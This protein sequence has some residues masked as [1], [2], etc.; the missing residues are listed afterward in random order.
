MIWFLVLFEG[1]LQVCDAVLDTL[2]DSQVFEVG[3][4]LQ[5]LCEENKLQ[6]LA[7]KASLAP[8]IYH[9]PPFRK[10]VS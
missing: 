8:Y 3:Q 5:T 6:F 7:V 9:T 1:L 10:L 4:T 2:R